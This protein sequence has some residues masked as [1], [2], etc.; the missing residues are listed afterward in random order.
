MSIASVKNLQAV[1]DLHADAAGT[2]V[3]GSWT[4]YW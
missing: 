1:P 2:V 3:G 4:R